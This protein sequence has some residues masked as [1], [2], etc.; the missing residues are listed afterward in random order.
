MF[1][2]RSKQIALIGYDDQA[3]EL[4]VQYHTGRRDSFSPIKKKMTFI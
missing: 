1:P 3:L 2:I 4:V